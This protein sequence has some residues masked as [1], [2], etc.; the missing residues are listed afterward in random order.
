[1]FVKTFS[2]RVRP[3]KL[4]V[5]LD[6]QDRVCRLYDQQL[7]ERTAYLQNAQDPLCWVEIHWFTDRAA[8]EVSTQRIKHDPDLQ[9]LWYQFSGVLDPSWP[10]QVNEYEERVDLGQQPPEALGDF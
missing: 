6:I 3:D 10:I 1:M 2:Y 5:Y 8:C 7:A 4:A 9:Q